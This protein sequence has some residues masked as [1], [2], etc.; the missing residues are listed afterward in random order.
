[1]TAPNT[2]TQPADQFPE[3][4]DLLQKLENARSAIVA[5]SAPLR[6]ERDQLNA[7]IAPLETR[8]RELTQQIRAIELPRLAD[9]DNRIAALHRA[10]G[11]RSLQEGARP[12]EATA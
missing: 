12:N 7:Q 9:L 5:Q 3:F 2:N 10:M 1:M 11:A 8:H 6:T 4:R